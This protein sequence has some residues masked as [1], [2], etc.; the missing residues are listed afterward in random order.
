MFLCFWVFLFCCLK[1]LVGND[2]EN[3]EG[4]AVASLDKRSVMGVE[5]GGK[6]FYQSQ[7]SS[8]VDLFDVRKMEPTIH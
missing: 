4:V 2:E 1:T 3:D 5:M 6:T 7:N 8:N